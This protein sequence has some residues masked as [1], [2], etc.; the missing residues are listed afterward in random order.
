MG[1]DGRRDALLIA[2]AY[3]VFGLLWIFGTDLLA[4]RFAAGM[5]EMR[6]LETLKGWAFVL[7]SAGLVYY[8]VHRAFERHRRSERAARRAERI[9]RLGHWEL[10]IATM[11]LTW[12]DE[13]YR[14]F[15]V[16]PTTFDVTYE[17]FLELVHP[18]DRDEQLSVDAAARAG[19]DVLDVEH[20][21][22][23]PDG[24]VRVVHERATL[25]EG[26]GEAG[27]LVGTVQDVTE[28][29]RLEDE[30]E[31]SRDLLRRYAAHL[32][33]RR[34]RERAD[35]ARDI[36]DHLGQLLTAVKL[37]LDRAR[38]AEGE[39]RSER[40][41]ETVELVEESIDEVREISSQLRPAYVDQLGLVDGLEAYARRFGEQ[42]GVS[43]R[44]QSELEE[45]PLDG[46]AS[47]HLFRIVQEALTNVA[48]HAGA[49]RA[50]VV[51]RRED[52]ALVVRVLDDGRGLREASVTGMHSHGLLGMNERAR[53][54]G[55]SFELRDRDGAG[56]EARVSIPWPGRNGG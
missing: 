54:L 46:E 40:L 33:T 28:R 16:D 29:R 27:R 48:R 24:E 18:E 32:T 17:S 5:A 43:T 11:E 50:R 56:A 2:G 42:T 3:A 21:V 25:V 23:R 45:V 8:L 1:Q 47:V 4:E 19:E 35:L 9:G 26:E 20:R 13:V 49:D 31:R 41:D 36:H 10:D 52:D 6:R 53:L 30:L 12:S 34:E 37:R 7:L 15:G 51:L 39:V 55:G 14:I 44:L 38:F 22:V